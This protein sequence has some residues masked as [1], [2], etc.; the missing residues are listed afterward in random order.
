MFLYMFDMS[1]VVQQS[2]TAMSADSFL[3]NPRVSVISGTERVQG[4]ATTESDVYIVRE[5]L[6]HIEVYDKEH[7]AVKEQN[8]DV[9]EMSKVLSMTCCQH[10][11]CLYISDSS[12]QIHRVQL[13]NRSVTKWS[14]KDDS[15]GLSVTSN[16]NLLV[17]LYITKIIQEYTTQGSLVREINPDISTH[18]LAHSIEMSTGQ[19]VVCH[20]GR[21]QLRV[22]TVDTSGK[23]ITSYDGPTGSAAGQLGSAWCLAV[24]SQ[25]NVL[26]ADYN[27]HKR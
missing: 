13:S 6:K 22:L 23:V 26:V 15:C 17:S 5:G 20:T 8:I 10:Y 7:V 11:N 2:Q 14:I 27:N 19:I 3:V 12:K 18:L 16:H 4:I 9:L 1:G 24:D 25:N 21:P